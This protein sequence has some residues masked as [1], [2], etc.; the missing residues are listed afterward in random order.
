[1]T[2]EEITKQYNEYA[3]QIKK[4][5]AEMFRLEGKAQLIQEME[6]ERVE[7]VAKEAKK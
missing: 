5:E 3:L 1:M 4:I 7:K 6:K 2:I